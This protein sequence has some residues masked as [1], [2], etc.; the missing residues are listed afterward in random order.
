MTI[1]DRFSAWLDD[2]L[3]VDEAVE[4][5]AEIASDPVLAAEVESLR[6]VRALLR[7]DGQVTLRAE[8]VDALMARVEE[9]AEE[10][11]STRDADLVTFTRRRRVP[12]FA[13]AAASCALVVSV[14]G[15]IGGGATLPAVGELIA[16]HDA[17]AAE[18][19]AQRRTPPVDDMPEMTGSSEMAA[20]DEIDGVAHAVYVADDGSIVSVF[21]QNGE[22]DAQRQADTMGGVTSA[23]DG[24]DMWSTDVDARHVVVLDGDGYVWT[25]VSDTDVDPMIDLMPDSMNELPRR[26]PALSERVR[27][28]V[29]TCVK[30]FGLTT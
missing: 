7:S 16:R 9:G 22:F 27:A 13:A 10:G 30:P 29:E 18:P 4:V 23:M 19:A 3:S 21:R 15:G 28:V 17:A 24:H 26:T 12:A 1:D 8:A 14:V 5:V 2:E 20:V 11:P 6:E 25:L